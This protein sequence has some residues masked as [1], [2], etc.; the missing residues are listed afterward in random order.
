[1]QEIWQPTAKPARRSQIPAHQPN[2]VTV[3]ASRKTG[4]VA[5]RVATATAL[6][7]MLV[8]STATFVAPAA[9]A[10]STTSGSAAP[11][12]TTAAAGGTAAKVTT[13]IPPAPP[14]LKPN[15][16]DA[17]ITTPPTGYRTLQLP[18]AAQ[19]IDQAAQPLSALNVTTYGQQLAQWERQGAK[20]VPSS[21]KISINPTKYVASHLDTALGT[22]PL[23][24]YPTGTLAGNTS[25]ALAWPDDVSYVDYKFTVP[26]TGLYQLNIGYRDFPNCFTQSTASETVAQ[27]TGTTG[28]ALSV[29][30][31]FCGRESQAERGVMI[32][33]PGTVPTVHLAS[34]KLTAAEQAVINA[35]TAAGIPAANLPG[36][37]NPTAS[38]P[39]PSPSPA[40][41]L[42]PSTL[43]A[44]ASGSCSAG[45]TP[46]A[47]ASSAASSSGGSATSPS[48][49]TAA[50]ASASG[51][52]SASA[53]TP[54]ASS[55]STGSA[56]ASGASGAS[57]SSTT[58]AS[59]TAAAAS[60][61]ASASSGATATPAAPAAPPPP[62][63][64]CA[65][66]LATT[67]YNGYQ[68]TEAQNIPFTEQW[69]ETGETISPKTGYVQYQKDNRGDDL[70]PIPVESETWQNVN[71]RDALAE[72]ANPL[73]FC[74]T[75][76]QHILRLSM[77]TEPMAI[78][79]ITFQGA[80]TIPT[81]SQALQQWKSQGMTPVT[82]GMC[83][84]VQG[85]AYTSESDPTIS[86]GTDSNPTMV[87]PANGYTILNML[88]GQYWEQP[89]Q[90]VQYTINAPQTGLYELS[91]KELQ[92]G[93]EGLPAGRAM[94]IDGKTPFQGA[95]WIEIPF[96]NSWNVV[97]LSQG[98][99]KPALIGLT[100]GKHTI[101]FR[102]TLGLV[103]QSLPMIQASG[104]RLDELEQEILMVTGNN[105]QAAVSYNLTQNVPGLI[106]Q[107]RAVVKVLEQ[108]AAL[109]DYTAGGTKPVAANSI[110]IAAHDIQNLSQ[111][112][113][114]IQVNTTRWSNDAQSLD[115]WLSTLEAQ[116]V[117]LDWFS[118]TTPGYPLPAPNANILKS[119]AVTWQTFILS[120]YRNY[121]GVGSVY[122]HALNVWVGYGQLWAQIM[123]QLAASEFTP[124]THLPINFD[125]IPG[126]SGI[127]LLA[128]VSGHGPDV[129]TGM[130]ATVP[131]DFAL[132]N[133]AYDLSSMP[134]WPRIAS[135]FVPNALTQYKFTNAQGHTGVYGIPETQGMSLLIY[136]KDILKTL[137]NG[138]PVP[139][140]STWPELFQILPMITSKGMTFYYPNGPTGVLPFLYQ[141]GGQYY[142]GSPTSPGGIQA[143][144]NT[145]QGYAAFK[146]WTN[147]F[148]Q[149]KTPLSSNFFTR[150][151]EGL[152]PIGVADYP[153]FVQFQVAAP[154][155]QGL[156]GIA[157]IPGTPYLC[158]ASG[159]VNE[160][161]A[162]N[163]QP[164]CLY[165]D[166][167]ANYPPLPAGDTCKINRTAG[168]TNA[169]IGPA[170]SSASNAIIIPKSAKNPQG[171][172]QFIEWWTSAQTQLQ[173]ATDIIAVAGVQAAWN[174]AN[175]QALGG[176]PW[177]E[178]DLKVFQQAWS[179][180][181]PEPV[182]PGG[183]ISDRYINDVWTNVV[184]NGQNVR[185]Q[186][187]W[188]T[189]NINDELYRQEVMYGLVK[190]KANL[191]AQAGA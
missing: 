127:V 152:Q 104:Q 140:P 158:D 52:S 43:A 121:T 38:C 139:V 153:T 160:M 171:A 1:M 135:R 189:Q 110:L 53:A 74:L 163:P 66:N 118:L 75:A 11:A 114:Q 45:A 80:A 155:L 13:A 30:G 58:S 10:A 143:D 15:L 18:A 61:T 170:A 82:C 51:G 109:L 34:R 64:A 76:G 156:M 92:A 35:A 50:S 17:V 79:S 41:T 184:E 132:R 185:A 172:W 83:L 164:A 87:P 73:Q 182:V 69:H 134:N 40:W 57:T 162:A 4:D 103:G 173:F 128:Q 120:F 167:A 126:G 2:G 116:P 89:N 20:P 101:R 105:P 26:Q 60:A 29:N 86:P 159:C 70:Y 16:H 133:G 65:L 22:T 108:Q 81:Y 63:P 107:M 174:T 24:V 175:V 190:P 179:Q 154:Q 95:Q 113:L 106:P 186:L 177:P 145:Q 32:D 33:P 168:D 176:L 124:V 28:T 36:W 115:Q 111:H 7:A 71:V 180:Y 25:P 99:G 77:V 122:G 123:S 130:P 85:E 23:K 72:Y 14:A 68:Y 191:N 169:G 157:P 188:A 49:S 129:A 46:T 166:E 149:W 102:V 67:G 8:M 44:E 161:T 56:S 165:P 78:S 90:W 62:T 119:L 48:G 136:R 146:V 55:A 144:L 31:P 125:I 141:F 112:P 9:A 96:K 27:V 84:M 142:K 42:M 94:T 91:F 37:L 97:T 21:V 19:Y 100:K 147:L 183:Y 148:D 178:Q 5:R 187:Q 150:F 138:K 93:L 131:V 117:S 98:N 137:N 6:S 88:N 39:Q 47:P 3:V 54:S 12:S 181:Q 151:Q 59:T